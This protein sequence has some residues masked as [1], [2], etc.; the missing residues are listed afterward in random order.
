MAKFSDLVSYFEQLATEHAS[1]RHSA[2]NH[3]FYRFELDE[4]LTGM[5]TSLNYPALILEGYDFDFTDA[6]SDNVIKNRHGAFILIDKVQ[7]LKDY[8]RIHEVWDNL[9]EIGTDILIRMLEDKRNRDVTVLRDFD[10]SESIGQIFS[11]QQLG[12]HGLR[13]QFTVSSA[14]N[15]VHDTEKWL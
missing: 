14:V 9:E 2:K 8:N 6:G 4:V 7:D 1:I 11:V 13:F 12:Q 10:I 15:N 3:H 5:C